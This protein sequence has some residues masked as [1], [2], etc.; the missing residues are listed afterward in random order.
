MKYI[1]TCLLFLF[2]LVTTGTATGFSE[3]NGNKIQIVSVTPST[4]VENKAQEVEMVVDYELVSREEGIVYIGFN[5]NEPKRYHLANN[6]VVT[7]GKGRVVLK[8]VITPRNW[9][10]IARFAAFANLSPFPHGNRWT[11]LVMTSAP[12]QLA[13]QP[14]QE[15]HYDGSAVR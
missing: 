9:G 5:T 11:P 8:A 3:G 15:P 14:N 10:D 13:G 7:A 2:A 4:M 1:F 12:V 6:V